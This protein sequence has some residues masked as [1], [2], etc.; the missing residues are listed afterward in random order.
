MNSVE[1]RSVFSCVPGVIDTDGNYGSFSI[2]PLYIMHL[3]LILY[4]YIK[5][6]IVQINSQKYAC[7][8]YD[9]CLKYHRVSC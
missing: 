2:E 3:D 5:V 8:E 4:I 6:M 7:F 1:G 9:C